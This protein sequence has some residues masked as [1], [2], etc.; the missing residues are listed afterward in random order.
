MPLPR[1]QWGL[2]DAVP[3]NATC[4]WGCRAIVTQDGYID[5]VP[6]R[7]DRQ[8]SAVIFDLLDSQFPPAKLTESLAALLRSGQM[9]TRRRERFVLY[10]SATLTV[11]ADTLASAGYCYVAAWTTTCMSGADRSR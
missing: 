8:G 7:V 2:P 5:I 11:A 3:L 9:S 6:D 1:L 4:A 10:E